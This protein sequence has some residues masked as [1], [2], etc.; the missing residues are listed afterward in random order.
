MLQPSSCLVRC[1]HCLHY[2]ML[3]SYLTASEMPGAVGIAESDS[4]LTVL[5]SLA[6][7]GLTGTPYIRMSFFHS[8]FKPGI[9]SR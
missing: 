6:S 7:K 2:I 8:L 5:R 1:L 9:R 3:Y 4:S